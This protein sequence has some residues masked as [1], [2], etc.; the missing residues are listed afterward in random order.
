MIILSKK[1]LGNSPKTWRIIAK[2]Q[3]PRWND[4]ETF[5]R[6]K[7]FLLKLHHFSQIAKCFEIKDLG[8]HFE[9]LVEHYEYGSLRDGWYLIRSFL[10]YQLLSIL[11]YANPKYIFSMET[12][13]EWSRQLFRAVI[14]LN[15]QNIGHQDI[16]PER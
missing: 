3:N 14:E 11:V 4:L 12:I 7:R 2:S 16:T 5:E 9:V 10:I 1:K 13:L 6:E 8:D 15:N